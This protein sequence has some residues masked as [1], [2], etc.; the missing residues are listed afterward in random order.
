MDYKRECPSKEVLVGN[1][2]CIA[3]YQSMYQKSNMIVMP[4]SP[5]EV[6][7]FTGTSVSLSACGHAYIYEVVKVAEVP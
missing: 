5:K 4:Q 1:I 2:S 7:S 3:F 6:P